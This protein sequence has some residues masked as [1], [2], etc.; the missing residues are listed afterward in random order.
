MT[1]PGPREKELRPFLNL[2]G[3]DRCETCALRRAT[4]ADFDKHYAE[5]PNNK[6][7]PHNRATG[8]HWCSQVC[9]GNKYD[10]CRDHLGGEGRQMDWREKF[11]LV[12]DIVWPQAL[13]HDLAPP[14]DRKQ[15]EV[16]LEAA[17]RL[18]EDM[19]SYA[20]EARRYDD[21]FADKL[22]ARTAKMEA[23]KG[24]MI[25]AKRQGLCCSSC[26]WFEP[27]NPYPL[28]IGAWV[29]MTAALGAA[30]KCPKKDG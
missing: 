24:I 21:D 15:V 29:F 8:T 10:G 26:D 1:G 27:Y 2:L 3:A 20:S 14:L 30:H 17:H 6:D 23:P 12:M 11:N 19:T 22:A 25:D 13:K 18:K 28:S 9:W 7:C 16:A 4:D 5:F